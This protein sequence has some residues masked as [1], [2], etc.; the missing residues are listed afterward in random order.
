MDGLLLSGTQ[1]IY[2]LGCEWISQLVEKCVEPP[3]LQ[4]NV[5]RRF[6]FTAKVIVFCSEPLPRASAVRGPR[7]TN[8]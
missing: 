1:V 3:E 4:L 7:P 5:G 2:L 8:P 6:I